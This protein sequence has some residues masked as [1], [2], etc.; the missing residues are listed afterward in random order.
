MKKKTNISLYLSSILCIVPFIVSLMFYKDLPARIATHW[1]SDGTPNGFMPKLLGAFAIPTIIFVSHILIHFVLKID[2]KEEENPNAL[3]VLGIWIAPLISV[4]VQTII[5]VNAISK[6]INVYTY[7]SLGIGIL[8]I[9]IG[10]YLP[11]SRQNV[12]V[13]IKLPWTLKSEENWNKTNRLTGYIWIIG[14]IIMIITGFF[15]MG[16]IMCISIIFMLIIPIIY[17]YTQFRKEDIRRD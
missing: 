6:P 7:V 17:S 15:N 11:K 4:V 2:Y 8:F 3:K 1:N 9:I 16:W 14:G 13:G 10:N 5:I 12:V